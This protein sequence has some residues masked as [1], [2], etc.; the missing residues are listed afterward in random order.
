MPASGQPMRSL[1]SSVISNNYASS[2]RHLCAYKIG[3]RE[4]TL[5]S[6]GPTSL[7]F[8]P[9]TIT[10]FRQQP[11][12]TYPLQF[13][14][15]QR[16]F[17]SFLDRLKQS[18]QDTVQKV[19]QKTQDTVQNAAQQATQK[20]QSVAKTA[21]KE[22]QKA[23]TKTLESTQNAAI[24]AKDKA[25]QSV[26]KKASEAKSN[27]AKATTEAFQ[28]TVG[29]A[30]Q[31]ISE[32]AAN[33]TKSTTQKITDTQKAASDTVQSVKRS[34]QQW[35]EQF[36]SFGSK[37]LRWFWWWSL[38]A[39]FVYGVAST[40]P[41]AIIK[42]TIQEK[43]KAWEERSSDSGNETSNENE[44]L[45]IASVEEPQPSKPYANEPQL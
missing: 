4:M 41:M 35:K 29:K 34:S 23:A 36:T 5:R 1:G 17:S 26:T 39:I 11:I 10:V 13:R 33:A 32:T 6:T 42:Y 15:H 27:A 45:A 44:A 38:A 20:A 12:Q 3:Y 14:Q 28:S 22:A 40:L 19:A 2:S 8:S 24:Q 16:L 7:P 31:Q 25:V 21:T 18:T 43:K 37:A 30:T 9:T